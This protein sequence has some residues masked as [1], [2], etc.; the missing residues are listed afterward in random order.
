LC[1]A[2]SMLISACLG[3][4]RYAYAQ[5]PAPDDSQTFPETGH[6]IRG[7]FLEYWKDHGGL[8]QQGYPLTEEMQ[9]VS[10]LNGKTY[11]VQYFERALF[12]LHPENEGTP[13]EVLLSQ[14]GTFK[15]KERNAVQQQ[16]P[17]VPPPGS[18]Y[19]QFG[20]RGSDRYL[21]WSERGSSLDT[22]DL[23]GLDLKTNK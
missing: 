3:S 22:Y 7:R 12:E 13:Y 19:E 21:V 14:L 1:V 2:L 18:G 11:T 15:L 17:V 6:S 5:A 16:T 20:P 10:E 23:K 8:V 9:E 4:G